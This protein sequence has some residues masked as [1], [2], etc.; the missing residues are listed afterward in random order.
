MAPLPVEFHVGIYPRFLA[1]II[2]ALASFALGFLFKY[3]IG[4]TIP[5]FGVVVPGVAVA[6]VNGGLLALTDP[7][8]TRSEHMPATL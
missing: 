6:G 4:L 7:S 3:V 2:P 8:I 1:G 5:A